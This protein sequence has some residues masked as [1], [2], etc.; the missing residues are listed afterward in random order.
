[1]RGWLLAAVMVGCYSPQ[2]SPGAPCAAGGDCPS[3]L[4]CIAGLCVLPGSPG[5][6]APGPPRDAPVV[7]DA[8]AQ[9]DAMIPPQDAPGDALPSDLVAYWACDDDP[10]DGALDST[11]NGH[12]AICEGACPTLVPGKLGMAYQFDATQSEDLVVPDSTAFRGN[13]TVSAW[14][15]ANDAT[16]SLSI[17]AKPVGTGTDNSW[18]LEVRDNGFLSFSGGSVHYLDSP[19]TITRNVWHHAAGTWDGTTKRLYLD[20]VEVA[21]VAAT[22]SYDTHGVWLGAD[23]NSGATALYF[24]GK[25]DELRVYSRALSAQEIA[26]L[27]Q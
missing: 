21:N 22:L 7:L 20:G 16:A 23:Q 4:T 18:Q 1:M 26:A 17:L 27:A 24:S 25:L 14:F 9:R 3:G 11:G 13:V 10:T 6:D 8:P 2:P 5:G 15:Y 12:T 19:A